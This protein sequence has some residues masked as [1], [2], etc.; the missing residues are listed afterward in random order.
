MG[1]IEMGILSCLFSS[2]LPDVWTKDFSTS[3]KDHMSASVEGSKSHS[4]LFV[5]SSDSCLADD[6]SCDVFVK[7]MQDSFADLL[8]VDDFVLYSFDCQ[9][10]NIILLSS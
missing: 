1:D 8:S 3:S 6:V 10:S 9:C 7:E 2:I 4:S 5:D